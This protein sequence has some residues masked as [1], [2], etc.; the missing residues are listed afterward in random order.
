LA[1]RLRSSWCHCCTVL[2]IPRNAVLVQRDTGHWSWE[3]VAQRRLRFVTQVP[4]IQKIY[5]GCK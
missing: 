5:V 3:P 4:N 2:H 1:G